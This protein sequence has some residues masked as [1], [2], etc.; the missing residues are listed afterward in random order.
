M[1]DQEMADSVWSSIDTHGHDR[2]TN[3]A[4]WKEIKAQQDWVYALLAERNEL[5]ARIRD[6]EGRA[7]QAV[8]LVA[9]AVGMMTPGNGR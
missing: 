3:D 2:C 5:L 7:A 1:T 9:K 8:E 4:E 6:L